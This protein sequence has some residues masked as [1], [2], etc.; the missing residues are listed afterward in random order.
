MARTTAFHDTRFRPVVASEL[1]N[2]QLSISL[3]VQYERAESPL[4]WIIG[5]HG[6]LIKFSAA[7][8][9]FNATYLPEV[10]GE[11]GW[12]REEAVQSLVRKAGFSGRIEDVWASIECTR[13]Q[14][15]KCFMTFTE[16]RDAHAASYPR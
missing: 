9:S 5:K 4:D 7:G 12:T 1:E 3:L 16:W 14:S 15:A 2:L 10:A 11:Q 8:S 13:Y 6:I